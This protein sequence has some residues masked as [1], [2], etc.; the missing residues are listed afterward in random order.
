MTVSKYII[1]MANSLIYGI[2]IVR[3]NRVFN[4]KSTPMNAIILKYLENLK[5]YQAFSNDQSSTNMHNQ[6]KQQNHKKHWR[7]KFVC[8]FFWRIKK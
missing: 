6:T 3:N 5:E 1:E 7:K 2:W 8:L 4:N